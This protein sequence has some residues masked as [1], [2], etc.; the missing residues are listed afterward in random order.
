MKSQKE[1][2]GIFFVGDFLFLIEEHIWCTYPTQLRDLQQSYNRQGNVVL[3]QHEQINQWKK[4]G[5][6]KAIKQ[7]AFMYM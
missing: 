7:M 3:P 2:K 4:K 5:R 6:N 1:L